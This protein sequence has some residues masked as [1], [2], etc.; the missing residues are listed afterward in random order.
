MKMGKAT[1]DAYGDALLELGKQN[2]NIVIVDGDVQNSTRAEAFAK[3]FP[4]RA[5]QVGIAEANLVGVGAGLAAAG[6]IPF[7]ASFAV[8]MMANAFDQLRM[9]VAFPGLNVKVVGSHAGISI[10]EDGPSQMGIEDIGLAALLPGFTVITP[11]DEHA[12]R[13]ATH[14]IA[15][16]V[17]PCYLR[18]GR[19]KA[20]VIYEDGCKQFEIG[21]SIQLR[22]GR[23]VTIIANGL[24]LGM[25]LEAAEKLAAEGIQARVLD[26]HTIKPLDHEAVEKAARETGGIVV[27]EEHLLRGGLGSYVAMSVAENYPTHMRFIGLDD[28]YAESGAPEALLEKYGLTSHHI[29]D[30][31]RELA[32]LP[33]TR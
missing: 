9:S 15:A 5:F 25:A 18:T 28:V 22:D 23:D 4:D 14:A 11:A 1:R 7:I 27:A 30:C 20:P 8:F 26:M 19:Q 12:A 24:M 13:A 6:K 2:P 32:H 33:R 17:G 16:H 29:A 31:A 10:G 3:A 21:K